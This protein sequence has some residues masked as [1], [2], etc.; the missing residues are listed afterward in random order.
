ARTVEPD[1]AAAARAVNAAATRGLSDEEVA[2]FMRVTA[3]V[4][5][6]LQGD[7]DGD[8][9]SARHRQARSHHVSSG[10]PQGRSGGGRTQRRDDGLGAAHGGA[11]GPQSI[12]NPRSPSVW[13]KP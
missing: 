11:T 13:E 2:D 3:T 6:N 4:I 9:R 8:D 5:G 7:A 12:E 10:Q 1:L